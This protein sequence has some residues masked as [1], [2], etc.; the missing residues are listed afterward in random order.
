MTSLPRLLGHYWLTRHRQ[1][2][3]RAELEAWQDRQVRRQLSRVTARSPFY[4]E[5]YRGRDLADWRQLPQIDKAAMMA[6]FDRLNTVG[7][8]AEKAM[9][10]ALEAERSRDFSPMIGDVTV[11]LSSGTDA[12]MDAASSEPAPN[13][14]AR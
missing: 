5:L 2:G 9:A 3:T 10:V 14:S 4:A 12:S 11:G 1:F 8:T 13:L 7:L 6:G